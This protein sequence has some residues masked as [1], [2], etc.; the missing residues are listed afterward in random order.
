MWIHRA[1]VDPTGP[2]TTNT[3][4]RMTGPST[5]GGVPG[6]PAILR[7]LSRRG[8]KWRRLSGDLNGW[9]ALGVLVG[10]NCIWSLGGRLGGRDA[11][12]V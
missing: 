4:P 12:H 3:G 6:S 1:G 5:S 8:A 2:S 7:S 9:L 11:C 10:S